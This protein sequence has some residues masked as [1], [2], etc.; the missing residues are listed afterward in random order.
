MPALDKLVNSPFAHPDRYSDEQFHGLELYLCSLK[1]P[2]NPNKFDA[3]AAGDKKV[4]EREWCAGCHTPP[5]ST[6]LV[7]LLGPIF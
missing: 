6:S 3:L 5:L 7:N 2:P 4:F 1:P